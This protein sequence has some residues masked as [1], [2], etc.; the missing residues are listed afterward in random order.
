VANRQVRRRGRRRRRCAPT[1]A[2]ARSAAA[3]WHT[4]TQA[5]TA[6]SA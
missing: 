1:S 3:C 5:T 4:G 6:T 2:C